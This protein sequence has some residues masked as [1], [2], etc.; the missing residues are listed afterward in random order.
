[1]NA[2]EANVA[3]ECQAIQEALSEY[4]GEVV[5]LGAA[6][7]QHVDACP[8]CSEVAAAEKALGLIFREAVA[9]ADPSVFAGVMSALRPVRIRRRVVAFVPV[10]A[11]LLLA[12]VGALLIGGVPGSGV[13][14]LLPGWSSQGWSA[15]LGGVSDWYSAT[16]TG[17][18]AA[19]AA[20]DP[21]FL[22]AACV[23]GLIGLAGVVATARR[24]RKISPW[25]KN[26]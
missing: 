6:E 5:R 16:S 26:G 10:A 23:I 7:R 12:V 1:L 19:T 22:A 17:V 18:S 3:S 21:A 15:M 8:G 14:S 13:V 20:M 24:W 4:R 9:P 11:S 2:Q 25:R